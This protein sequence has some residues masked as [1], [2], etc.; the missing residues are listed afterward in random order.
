M[1]SSLALVQ[2]GRGKYTT[3]IDSGAVKLWLE[4]QR[5][6]EKMSRQTVA[7]TGAAA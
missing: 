6:K 2:C 5:E 3:L 4:L 1:I 7:V